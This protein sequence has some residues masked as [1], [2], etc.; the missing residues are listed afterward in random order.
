MKKKK[1]EHENLI[2]IGIFLIK[3]PQ[4]RR[5]KKMVKFLHGI[6]NAADKRDEDKWTKWFKNKTESGEKNKNVSSNGSEK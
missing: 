6:R 2:F 5:R 1:V 4:I 3:W